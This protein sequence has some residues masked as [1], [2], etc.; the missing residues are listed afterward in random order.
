MAPFNKKKE[1]IKCIMY[2]YLIIILPIYYIFL[3]INFVDILNLTSSF[4]NYTHSPRL[5]LKQ[6]PQKKK[7]I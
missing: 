2:Y 7:N 1:Y 5:S 4:L 6:S 3:N